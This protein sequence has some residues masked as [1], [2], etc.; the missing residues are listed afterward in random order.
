M[1]NNATSG[2]NNAPYYFQ[3]N[4]SFFSSTDVYIARGNPGGGCA[5]IAWNPVGRYWQ[6]RLADSVKNLPHEWIA[7][8]IAHEL[9]HALGL[10][11]VGTD[12]IQTI[13]NG[14]TGTSCEPIIKAIQATDVDLA[15]KHKDDRQHCT[16][17]SVP[18]PIELA[19][20]ST[21]T[22]TP[23]ECYD[24]DLDGYG[25][26]VGCNGPDCDEGNPNIHW[27]AYLGSCSSVSA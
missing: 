3:V 18:N 14:T 19:P 22:P 23:P 1:W 9:G 15:R 16:A 2:G 11:N 7:A 21:P 10:T 17:Q 5:D 13:M 26:G 12:C 24:Y 4:Q 20:G 27:G 6:M 8:I 25:E